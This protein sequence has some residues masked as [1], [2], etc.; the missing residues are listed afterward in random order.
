MTRIC[1]T[2]M[3]TEDGAREADFNAAVLRI[4]PSFTDRL[5]LKPSFTGS[6]HER[7]SPIRSPDF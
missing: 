3:H 2:V 5:D 4:L 6:T 1:A 7:G